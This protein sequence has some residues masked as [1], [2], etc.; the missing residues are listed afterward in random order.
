MAKARSRAMTVYSP[1][2]QAAPIIKVNVPRARSAPKAKRRHHRR[3]SSGGGGNLKDRMTKLA[4]GGAALGY[5]E[6]SGMA[7]QLPTIP[8]IGRKGTVAIA[9]Y[10]LG[11]K[12]PGLLQDVALAAA[13]LA[14]YEL[15]HDG[16]I[17][18]DE[19]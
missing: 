14:G 11:G 18:G 4:I 2:R 12:K 8:L 1:P 16:K 19:D 5:I 13:V 10:Y 3:A 15:G 9:A 7:S 17:S 6:K